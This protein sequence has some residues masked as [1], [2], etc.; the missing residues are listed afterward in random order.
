MSRMLS[1]TY[2]DNAPRG[3]PYGCCT[4]REIYT[5]GG[6]H[7]ARIRRWARARDQRAWKRDA[8]NE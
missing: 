1:K 7:D 6:K 2:T 4:I 8:K 5:H 3:C